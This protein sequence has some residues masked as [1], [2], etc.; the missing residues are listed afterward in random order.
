MSYLAVLASLYPD[1][2]CFEVI[3]VINNHPCMLIVS[4]VFPFSAGLCSFE[5]GRLSRPLWEVLIRDPGRADSVT[6][7]LVLA[8]GWA[9]PPTQLPSP[10]NPPSMIW[11]DLA[12]A[13]Q[14][15]ASSWGSLFQPGFLHPCSLSTCRFFD[16]EAANKLALAQKTGY[17]KSPK[18]WSLG[19]SC[20]SM[21]T[22]HPTVTKQQK[23]NRAATCSFSAAFSALSG[24]SWMKPTRCP[25]LNPNP[26]GM[27]HWP[28]KHGFREFSGVRLRLLMQQ[29][30]W[31]YADHQHL[32]C[33]PACKSSLA[34]NLAIFLQNLPLLYLCFNFLVKS[35]D[36]NQD[37][38]TRSYEARP[39][40][41]SSC[42]SSSKQ[43]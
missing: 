9:P 29:A 5:A 13:E 24:A 43:T 10:W 28:Q 11:G 33:Q 35:D 19:R 39:R 21:W 34:L 27:K 25:L 42:F 1:L 8:N 7:R 20:F 32:A 18:L 22:H 16:I 6:S 14:S 26:Y 3:Q 37:V 30:S 23:K 2:L 40:S 38:F 15:L 36:F 41:K 17:I 12:I 4:P 31:L